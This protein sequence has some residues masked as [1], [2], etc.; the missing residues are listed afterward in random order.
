MA[1]Q[2]VINVGTVPNDG[3]GDPLR[4]A[5]QKSN[6][7]FSSLFATAVSISNNNTVG[8][9]ADQVIFETSATEF[10]NGEIIVYTIDTLSS[11]T[12]TIKLFAQLNYDNDDVKFTG[13]GSTFFGNALSTFNMDVSSG[14]VRVLASPLTAN[15]LFHNIGSQNFWTGP[16]IPGLELQLDGYTDTVLITEDGLILATEQA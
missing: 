7:N 16:Y 2:E 9:T 8:S 14:N 13:Y 3:L 12:Q 6:N 5:Y 15:T 10:S 1:T 4:T 11:E